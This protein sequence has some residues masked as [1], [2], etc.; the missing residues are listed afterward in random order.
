MKRHQQVA[1]FPGAAVAHALRQR[2]DIGRVVG[3]VTDEFDLGR[4]IEFAQAGD[5]VLVTGGGGGHRV[6]RIERQ[7]DQ[8]LD[9]GIAQQPQCRRERGITVAH[10]EFDVRLLEQA[11]L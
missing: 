7:Y 10:R 6:L 2:R 4:V 5:Q 3:I 1:R 11:R 8:P 9:T